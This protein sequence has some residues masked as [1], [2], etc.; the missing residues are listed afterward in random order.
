M[1]SLEDSL[2]IGYATLRK[3]RKVSPMNSPRLTRA[4]LG[5]AGCI[6]WAARIEAVPPVASNVTA[7]SRWPAY[8]T[9][10]AT[11]A[12]QINEYLYVALEEGGFQ[13]L[14]VKNPQEPVVLWSVR[15]P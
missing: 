15:F 12:H 10:Q 14:N 4:L 1:F 13:I 8:A 9:G 11:D 7:L 5:L 6:F 3:L 2:I